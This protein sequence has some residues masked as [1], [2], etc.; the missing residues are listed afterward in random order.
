MKLTDHQIVKAGLFVAAILSLCSLRA[1]AQLKAVVVSADPPM[2]G[3]AGGGLTK[4]VD[5]ASF[6]Y[7]ITQTDKDTFA[8]DD[9][10]GDTFEEIARSCRVQAVKLWSMTPGSALLTLR[11]TDGSGTFTYDLSGDAV[12]VTENTLFVDRWA[13]T[14][15]EL[16][17]GKDADVRVQARVQVN[18]RPKGE[19]AAQPTRFGPGTAAYLV[20]RQRI[21]VV[22]LPE[23]KTSQNLKRP[24]LAALTAEQQKAVEQRKRVF[25][26]VAS[27][28]PGLKPKVLEYIRAEGERIEDVR[29]D[30]DRI[31]QFDI[32]LL[33]PPSTALGVFGWDKNGVRVGF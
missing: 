22:G 29:I 8:W 27:L 32:V 18:L 4:A 28:P 14:N 19:P 13:L 31:E 6:F 17:A 30:L 10:A 9:R 7:A 26:P 11:G 16:D 3:T 1:N 23:Q 2:T 5:G 21:N 15:V 24:L 12:A 25:V 20:T 33:P